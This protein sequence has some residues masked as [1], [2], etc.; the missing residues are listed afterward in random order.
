MVHQSVMRQ[1]STMKPPKSIL[2]FLALFAVLQTCFFYSSASLPVNLNQDKNTLQLNN[3]FHQPESNLQFTFL[4]RG[5][6]QQE[7]SIDPNTCSFKLPDSSVKLT[8]SRARLANL[9]EYVFIWKPVQNETNKLCLKT[10]AESTDFWYATSTDQPPGTLGNPGIL[11]NPRTLGNPMFRSSGEKFAAPFVS[12]PPFGPI[13]EHLFISSTGFALFLDDLHPWAL[14]GNSQDGTLCFFLNAGKTPYDNKVETHPHAY[15]SIKF[16]IL[17]GPSL[18]DVWQASVGRHLAYI[19]R[20]ISAPSTDLFTRPILPVFPFYNS[21]SSNA[22]KALMDLYESLEGSK[23]R[24]GASPDSA[25]LFIDDVLKWTDEDALFAPGKS[26]FR[27]GEINQ[28]GEKIHRAG[29]EM[30]KYQIG[31][32]MKAVTKKPSDYNHTT[33]NWLMNPQG[34]MLTGLDFTSAQAQEYFLSNFTKFKENYP[35]DRF[36]FSEGS[37]ATFIGQ[38][39]NKDRQSD[40]SENWTFKPTGTLLDKYPLFMTSLYGKTVAVFQPSGAAIDAAYKMQPNPVFFRL[41]IDFKVYGNGCIKELI[42]QTLILATAG[43]QYIIPELTGFNDKGKVRPEDALL[44]QRW[45]QAVTLLPVM[46]IPEIQ[47]TT[48]I[49]TTPAK[50]QNDADSKF[51]NSVSD[52]LT[53]RKKLFNGKIE[54]LLEN[55]IQRGEPIVRPMWY[56]ADG[57]PDSDGGLYPIVDQFMLGPDIVVAPVVN[58]DDTKRDVFLPEGSWVN[59]LTNKTNIGGKPISNIHVPAEKLLYF[60][61]KA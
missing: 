58:P 17:V 15:F 47:T 43:Y 9:E 40:G 8:R 16:R 32:W 29:G 57:K 55:W 38:I 39:N 53:I 23:G 3:A 60:T 30:K 2:Q 11:D 7:D 50:A 44:F 52:C 51:F 37:L 61:R 49:Q 22:R 36:F 35:F 4:T 45:I 20:P 14:E 42:S 10:Q 56:A 26:Q 54:Q 48:E 46:T 24:K 18:K 5:A 1:N 27:M 13:I 6:L 31:I 41:K 19:R 28:L 25:V 33:E 34:D 21:V 12:I 59:G